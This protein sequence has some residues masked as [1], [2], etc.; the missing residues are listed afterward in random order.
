MELFT[1]GTSQN[2]WITVIIDREFHIEFII[3]RYIGWFDNI[4]IETC[5]S[6]NASLITDDRISI[7]HIVFEFDNSNQMLWVGIPV[8]IHLSI[9]HSFINQSFPSSFWY[10]YR[11][12]AGTAVMANYLLMVTWLPASV[13]LKERIS[14]FS[15]KLCPQFKQKVFSWTGIFGNHFQELFTSAVVKLPFLWIIS[16]GEFLLPFGISSGICFLLMRS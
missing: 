9:C 6:F 12:F 11:I 4:H 14:C 1:C 7:L 5:F 2:F 15:F 3:S 10:I 16:F 8:G 13:S